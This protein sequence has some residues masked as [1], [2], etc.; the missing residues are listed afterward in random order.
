MGMILERMVEWKASPLSKD[1]KVTSL[2]ALLDTPYPPKEILLAPWL[3]E[4][5]LSMIHAPAGVGKSL[6]G[7]SIALSVAAGG[8]LF[9]WSA[10][11]PRRVLLIDGEMDIED[12]QERFKTLAPSVGGDLEAGRQNL[13][14][15]ARQDQGLDTE[16]PDLA[17][18]AG[19][20]LILN[21]VKHLKPDLIILDNFST[22]CE[23]ENENDASSFNPIM[24]FMLRLKQG[25]IAVLLIHHSRKGNGGQSAYRGTSKMAV[26]F[27]TII[28]L[29]APKLIDSRSSAHF[30]LRWEKC[31]S[32][33]NERMFN[34]D[35]KLV[36]AEWVFGPLESDKLSELVALLKSLSHPDQNSLAETLG[37]AQGTISKWLKQA[38]A[39][40]LLHP[41]EAE[42]C[43]K[44]AQALLTPE[45]EPEF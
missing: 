27:N 25:R 31:R 9:E 26:V 13:S 21:Q 2:G 1:L 29:T 32:I 15:I 8:T 36:N 12:I 4:R 38:Q 30:E 45:V 28:N 43:F 16:F 3:T 23:V 14:V 6:L 35:V 7:A 22:L 20:G 24:N 19:Q 11:R 39:N 17:T 37:V 10:L 42:R 5:H 40:G 41:K 18:E 33:R 44:E 34:M